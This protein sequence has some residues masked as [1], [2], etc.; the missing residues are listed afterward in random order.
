MRKGFKFRQKGSWA[1]IL[2][3]ALLVFRAYI[4]AGFMPAD[5]VPFALQLCPTAMAGMPAVLP[6][7]GGRDAK[8]DP[9]PCGRPPAAG[10]ISHHIDFESAGPAPAQQILAFQAP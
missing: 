7:P 1:G 10:P 6:R 4:P 3:L 8:F 9:C 5:G 2:L